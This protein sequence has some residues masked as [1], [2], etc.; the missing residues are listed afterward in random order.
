MASS[1]ETKT[2]ELF[3]RDFKEQFQGSLMGELLDSSNARFAEQ[4]NMSNIE[5]IT[6]DCSKTVINA[7][8]NKVQPTNSK[9]YKEKTS[10]QGKISYSKVDKRVSL[11]CSPKTAGRDE[12]LF[13]NKIKYVLGSAYYTS[14]NVNWLNGNKFY[15]LLR[16]AIGSSSGLIFPY[17]PSIDIS[18]NVNYESVDITHTNLSYNYYKNTQPAEI[19]MSAKFTADNRDNAL[20]MLS[21]IWF[22][23]ACTKCDFG[24][25]SAYPGLPPPILYLNGYDSLIDNVPVIITRVSYKYPEDKH[26]V[27]LILDMN[28]DNKNNEAFCCIYDTIDVTKTYN[29]LYSTPAD[30]GSPK[31]ISTKKTEHLKLSFWLPTEISITLGLKVQ[32]NMLKTRKQWTL[33]AFKTG[34][35]L[36]EKGKNPSSIRKVISGTSVKETT[37]EVPLLQGGLTSNGE[38]SQNLCTT[39]KKYDVEYKYDVKSTNYIPSGWTW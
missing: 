28:A 36:T 37:K 19:S 31:P 23:V 32:P 6:T 34:L 1:A 5:P 25:N 9:L 17:T 12:Q 38:L 11:T 18:H 4:F 15:G 24:E 13:A 10:S 20:H 8:V 27:N 30:I 29:K 39:I 33:D 21:A 14:K 16:N 35:L 22:L 26:Y 2:K 3:T 7:T